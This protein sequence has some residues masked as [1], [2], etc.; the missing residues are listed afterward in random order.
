MPVTKVISATVIAPT[1]SDADALATTCSVMTIPESLKLIDSIPGAECMLV[2]SEG[3]VFYSPN[4]ANNPSQA[5]SSMEPRLVHFQSQ[6]A[7]PIMLIEF[8]ISKAD[9]G[10]TRFG[11]A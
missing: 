10:S 2:S 3:R 8:E 6:D 1:A 11:V 7:K 5:T 4:W 9:L